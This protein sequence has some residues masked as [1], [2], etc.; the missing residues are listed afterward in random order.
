[1]A[2]T[3]T[4]Y[5]VNRNV[6]IIRAFKEARR[7]GFKVDMAMKEVAMYNKVS[8]NLVNQVIYN[9]NYPYGGFYVDSSACLGTEKCQCSTR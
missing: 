9:P 3:L 6:G 7:K 5:Y 4:N 1:M 2:E 8:V